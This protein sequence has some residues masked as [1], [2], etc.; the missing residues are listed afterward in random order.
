MSPLS[1]TLASHEILYGEALPELMRRE[2]LADILEASA[3]AFPEK[4]ALLFNDQALSYRELNRRADQVASGLIAAGVRPGHI[5]GLCLQRGIDLLVMQAGIAKSGAAW[6]PFDADT[7]VERIAV[8][9]ED[10][11]AYGMLSCKA[12]AAQLQALTCPL[13]LAETF[14]STQ[15]APA[16]KRAGVLP[17]HP[18]YVI[19]TSG[20]TGK[21]KGIAVNQGS[22]CHF[23][24]S[25]NHVLGIRNSDRVYQGF[26]V[27]FDMSFEEI[28]ISYLAGATLWIAPKEISVDPEALPRALE[29]N[30]VT[31][32]HAVP[33]L[34][35]LFSQD[36]GSLRLINLGGEMCPEALVNRWARPGRQM[37]NTYGPT[38]ATVSAS[39]APLN[40]HQPVS[41]GKP[42][43][44]YGLMVVDTDSEHGLRLLPWGETGEL[45]ITGP[46]VA[47]GYL[48]RPDLTAEKFLAN[49]W[50]RNAHERRLY[51][52]G[53][54]A[55]INTDGS[56]QCLGRA[57]DQVKIRGFRVELGEIEAVLATQAGVATVAVLL[58]QEQGIDHLLAFIVKEGAAADDPALSAA[59][60]GA[61]SA[62]LPPYMVPARY[63]YLNEMPRLTSGKIDRNALKKRELSAQAASGESDAAQTPAEEVLFA[64]LAGLFPGQAIQRAGD[65]FSD[66]GGHSLMAAR[67]V[68]VLRRDSRYAYFKISDIYQSRTIG[69]IAAVMQADAVSPG[70]EQ[71]LAP[72]WQPPPGW[73]RWLCGAAQAAVIPWLVAMRMVQWLAPFFAYHFFTGELD[74]SIARA[75]VLSVGVFLLLTLAEFAIAIAG[76]WLIAGR[77]R[78]GR[79]PLWGWTYYRWWL[80][81]RLVEAAPTYMLS[82]SSLYAW[83]LRALGARVGKDVTIGSMTLR[84]PDLLQIGD[85]VSIGNASN[86]ENARV[87]H[88]ELLLGSISLGQ[89]AYVGSYA[90]L[91]GNVVLEDG[92]HLEG[93]SALA[94]GHTIPCQRIWQGSPAKDAGA[95][96]AATYPP[97]PHLSALRSVMETVFFFFGALLISAL[98]FMPVF[99]SFVT[100]DWFDSGDRFPWLQS[101]A[102]SFQ[103]VKY[104]ILAFPATAVLIVCTALLSAGIRWSILP[105]L[106]TGRYPVHGY[107]YCG[108]WLVNQIQES[109]LHVLHGVY[110][111][112]YAPFWYRLLGAKV[113]RGAEI[114]T[115]LGV[116]PDMLTLG[117]ETFIADAVLLGDEQIDGGWMSVQP[118]MIS[119]RSF[120]GNGAYIPDGT[121]LPENVLIGVHSCAPDNRQMHEGDT[122][123]GSPPLHLPAREVVRGFPENLTFRPSPFRRLGRGLIEAFRIIA[124]HA[125]VIA[126]G[127]TIVLN[128]MPLA[129][130]DRW[131]E[132]LYYLIVSGLLYGIGSFAFVLALK[133]LLIFRYKKSSVPMWTPFVWLSEGIT[134]LYEG[135]AVPNFM[136]YL[137][138]TP[139]LPLAFN[140]LG[141]KIGRG[142]YMDTTDITE[143]DCVSIGAH[144]EI[145]ALACPQTH[146]FEDRVM[147]IDQVSIGERVYMGPRSAVLY[148]AVVADGAELGALTL[149][150]KGEYIPAG[151]RWC[152]CPAAM[153]QF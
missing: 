46:G 110:A 89:D 137:R 127:Y 147:K 85:R 91:E 65:F 43:P 125:M 148:S 121:V 126:V 96:D 20:S 6:L 72:A 17:E 75:V 82:G 145:N 152:G 93:Q 136:R 2:I 16:L 63:E 54:L 8:C 68:S 47:T 108:K 44:N 80:A 123:L 9:L 58:R 55:C 122:W 92:A 112:V 36:V 107:T 118:T 76:K 134:N 153:T 86:F 79:Y 141:C 56:V 22:I 101:N 18:A 140:L 104:F 151:S 62:V 139:W 31:V 50:A 13:W 114:S 103:L 97:R 29:E 30:R 49:P 23:L 130:D 100:I 48:G 135:I 109:S 120:V 1:S 15:H 115:A 138:G 64:A 53:D 71:D 11:A 116:V 83:W 70:S 149:V 34:L 95:F 102:V 69:K 12:F 132:V 143:F 28:W 42:L 113:G 14:A 119:R 5:V 39:L 87:Q 3:L 4:T 59:L 24:R 117:D 74:D 99:P 21:P 35:A 78:P 142:V 45:C 133:W 144:S 66:L 51:R 131:G 124:P 32:L 84:A 146:L 7:P 40:A 73:K 26:S 10:A 37:F 106:K 38:E 67:L 90:V 33:T 41:I 57:D 19:Y 98:F 128:L 88:G 27:A 52:T 94:E 81:D 60:R 25:E 129:G 61:L 111:T 150:M 105:K 77:L